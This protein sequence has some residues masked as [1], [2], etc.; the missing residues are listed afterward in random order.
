MLKKLIGVSAVVVVLLGAA[1][2]WFVVRDDAPEELSVDAGG[3]SAEAPT[4]EAPDSFDGAWVIRTGGDTTAGFRIDEEFVGA[5]NHTAVGRS[6]EVE[7]SITVAG[8]EVSDGSFTVDLT[9]LEFTDDPPT[10]SVG[11]RAGSMEDRGLETGEFPEASFTLT[12]PIDLGAE[13]TAGFEATVEATGDLTL[14]GVTQEVTFMVD[15]QVDG[16]TI[17]VASADPVPVALADYDMD[18]PTPPFVA[19]VSDEGSFEL[20]LVFEQG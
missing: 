20:L 7:G 18:V 11:S 17:R 3:E 10:G 13:P 2:Y 1:V 9:T 4:G 14:H 8:T 15:A 6:P 19:S 12:Q 16:D 5:I